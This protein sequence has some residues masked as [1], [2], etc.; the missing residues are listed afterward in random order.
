MLL[1]RFSTFFWRLAQWWPVGSTF[2]PWSVAWST[3]QIIHDGDCYYLGERTAHG[4]VSVVPI[5]TN[6]YHDT[7]TQLETGNSVDGSSKEAGKGALSALRSGLLL[8]PLSLLALAPCSRSHHHSNAI[9]NTLHLHHDRKPT[10][11]AAHG[12]RR[13]LILL[14]IFK[15]S[16][17][18]N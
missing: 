1:Q 12:G 8:S 6:T 11:T 10:A 9:S 3:R 15:E 7:M 5:H 13:R 14:I 4:S 16:L 18:R 17:P 2:F